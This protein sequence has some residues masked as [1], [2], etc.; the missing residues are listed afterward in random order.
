M[1]SV[2]L[3]PAAGMGKRLGQEIPKALAPLLEVPLLV[4]TLQRFQPLGLLEDAVITVPPGQIDTFESVLAEAF[5]TT[6]FRCIE[7]GTERQDSVRIALEQI[8]PDADIVI[9]HDA[10]RPFVSSESIRE[11]IAAAAMLGAATVALPAI[12]TILEGDDDALLVH[13]P[14]RD[15]MWACQTPQLFRRALIVEAHQQALAQQYTGT[16]DASL[17]RWRGHP[18]QLVK[19]CPENFK[20]TTPMDLKFATLLLKEGFIS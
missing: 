5:P 13:T 8:P 7:G 9:I 15:R 6:V 20:V 18:V 12:D 11:G 14:P 10:A 2:L 17:V 1:K 3:I 19:G 16:D 4:W